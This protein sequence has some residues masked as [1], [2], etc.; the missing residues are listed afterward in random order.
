M[1]RYMAF[2]LEIA[3]PLPEGTEDWKALRPLGITCAATLTS[4]GHSTLFTAR[5][6]ICEYAE[7]MTTGQASLLVDHCW[8]PF[9][10]GTPS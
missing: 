3:L 10:P 7:R 6:E 9:R 5:N 2:D 1:T 4:D 8:E